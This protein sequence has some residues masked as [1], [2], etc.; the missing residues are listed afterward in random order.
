MTTESEATGTGARTEVQ[1]PTRQGGLRAAWQ[2]WPGR[3]L[4]LGVALVPIF[5]LF[6][7]VD[8]RDV[9]D[10]ARQVGATSM[11]L[12]WLALVFATFIGSVRWGVMMR[13]YGATETPPLGRMMLHNM[14]G[15]W[16]NVLPS[17]VAGDAVRAHRVRR[18]LPTPAT[19]FVVI[20]VERIAGLV[21]LCIV[22]LAALAVAPSR[23]SDI[24]AWTM[25]AGVLG[26]F[27]LGAGVFGL[28]YVLSRRPGLR[29]LVL[30]IPIA[31]P[32]IAWIPPAR[33][34]RRVPVAALMSVFT[35][36]PTVAAMAIPVLALSPQ[37]D[38]A[39]AFRII[40]AVI[41]FTYI[42]LTPGGFGQR[43]AAFVALFGT[44]GVSRAA[45]LTSSLLVFAAMMA[46]AATGGLCLLAER[47]LYPEDAAEGEA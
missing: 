4:R 29:E 13:A 10:H 22:A 7:R 41:L 20:F 1:A 33:D 26:A 44:V 21:G 18:Y 38:P 15:H 27:G 36:L 40:P 47:L 45:A 30:R 32:L 37:T 19:S 6:K 2:G 8:W 9:W 12:S 3:I 28:P 46:L 23:G 35:Q 34:A 43:E 14:V 16:F 39:T 24:V 17:G 25:R 11:L 31:G 5:Y 42:P